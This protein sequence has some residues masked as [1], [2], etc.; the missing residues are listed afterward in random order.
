MGLAVNAAR[1]VPDLH[2]LCSHCDV[3][4]KIFDKPSIATE[5]SFCNSKGVHSSGKQGIRLY[6][7]YFALQNA[8][9]EIPNP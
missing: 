9:W 3:L 4:P 5:K 2:C 7:C 1:F 6:K 8:C